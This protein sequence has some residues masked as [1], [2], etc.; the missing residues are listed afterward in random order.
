MAL[1]RALLVRDSYNSNQNILFRAADTISIHLG[2][3]TQCEEDGGLDLSLSSRCRSPS[4]A[5]RPP[6]RPLFSVFRNS[7]SVNASPS[8]KHT[9]YPCT[10]NAKLRRVITVCWSR[11]ILW[12][13]RRDAVPAVWL[14]RAW[15]YG[16]VRSNGSTHYETCVGKALLA[17]R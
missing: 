3:Q 16:Y 14:R 4:L 1:Q 17:I 12:H 7:I 15:T 9:C 8:N 5:H 6:T 11:S 10:Q 13:R 2:R